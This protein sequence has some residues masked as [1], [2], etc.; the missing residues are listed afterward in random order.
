[1][2]STYLFIFKNIETQSTEKEKSKK[3][4]SQMY[5][6]YI[7]HESSMYMSIILGTTHVWA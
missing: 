3:L 1:M 2:T 4:Y 5:K 6:V 7:S